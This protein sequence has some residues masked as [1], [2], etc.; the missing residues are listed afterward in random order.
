LKL[1]TKALSPELWE[2]FEAYFD[3]QGK[4]SGCWC[5]NHRLPV[6]CDFEGEAAR[7]AMQ[8]LVQ[9]RK[10]FGVLAYN[11]G[12]PIPVGWCALDRRKTLPG[13]D[14]IKEDIAC[15]H[16]LWS[17]HCI[18]SRSDFQHKGVEELLCKAAM[19]LAKEMSATSLEAYPEPESNPS[20]PYQTWNTF[21]G[22]QSTFEQLGFEKIEREYGE[23]ATFYTP[24]H[25]TL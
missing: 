6:G 4:A 21:N 25:K 7:L 18:T 5:M 17:I 9:H 19:T 8:Q 16:N 13:H 15:E 22:H 12:D 3:Y 2:D 24:M 23:N 20:Q 14:C 10:V 1:F 11:E